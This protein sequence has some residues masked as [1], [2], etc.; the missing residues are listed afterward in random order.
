MTENQ[1]INNINTLNTKEKKAIAE[2]LL[3]LKVIYGLR[4]EKIILYGSKARGDADQESDID[5]LVLIKDMQ[6]RFTE[7]RRINTITNEIDLKYDLFISAIPVDTQFF[8]VAGDLPF[9]YNVMSEGIA[10]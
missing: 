8:Q 1:H 3:K 7:S 9:Y 6:S 2:L 5:I 4:L 10:L